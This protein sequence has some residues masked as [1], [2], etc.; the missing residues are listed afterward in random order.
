MFSTVITGALAY[1][2]GR[3]AQHASQ[4]TAFNGMAEMLLESMKTERD[5]CEKKFKELEARFS[6]QEQFNRSLIEQLMRAGLDII[7]PTEG[8]LKLDHGTEEKIN[9]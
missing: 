8:F 7:R 1:F 2:G 9:V 4:Q 3:G 5:H 6:Q